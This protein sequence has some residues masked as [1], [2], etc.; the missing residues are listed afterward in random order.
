MRTTIHARRKMNQQGINQLMVDLCFE[1]GKIDQSKR[2]LGRKDAQKLLESMQDRIKVL[3]K[4][5]DKGGITLID[6]NNIFVTN[7]N[8]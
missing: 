7:Y 5:I 6:E 8:K 4:I 3:K 1:Y 2:L